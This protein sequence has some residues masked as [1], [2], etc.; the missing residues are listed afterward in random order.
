M[1][2]FIIILIA[3][4]S[5]VT[6]IATAIV[7]RLIAKRKH[8]V[9]RFGTV[10]VQLKRR[11]Q[12]VDELAAISK[13]KQNCFHDTVQNLL[14]LSNQARSVQSLTE[15]EGD[16]LR[17]IGEGL[18]NKAIARELGL[19]EGTVKGYV[20]QVLGKLGVAD[21]TQAALLAAKHLRR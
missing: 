1:R 4:I 7:M 14:F 5:L 20:S 3:V 15:R 17:L 12:L 10:E 2:T 13:T 8:A 9:R 6:L 19:S 21:R 18:S 16:V 11:Q